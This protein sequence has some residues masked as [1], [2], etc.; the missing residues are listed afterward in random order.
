[1]KALNVILID[2]LR[3]LLWGT[4]GIG[5]TRLYSQ[6]AF[7]DEFLPMEIHDFD[8][9]LPILKTS[10]RDLPTE[11]WDRIN[12]E[13]YQ[14]DIEHPGETHQRFLENLRETNRRIITQ[15]K[16][17]P[18]TVVLD[19]MSFANNHIVEEIAFNDKKE[20]PQ[21]EHYGPQK[22]H[23]VK[24]LQHLVALKCNVVVVG[25]EDVERRPKKS[26]KEGVG[27]GAIEEIHIDVTGK[28]VNNIPRYFNECYY[29]YPGFDEM[30]KAVTFIQTQV[31]GPV[32]GCKTS[33]PLDLKL[34]EPFE[35]FWTRV[36]AAWKKSVG[37]FVVESG[38]GD[39]VKSAD[40]AAG[41]KIS[42]TWNW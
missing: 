11:K 1:M 17:A 15:S 40:V 25:H 33:F 4:T 22:S 12:V 31:N 36:L 23:I 3:I 37:E 13:Q 9:G 29:L 21:F 19:S 34:N 42:R 24:Y 6:M 26:L 20:I 39:L 7:H 2:Y 28:L 10:L 16:E 41:I 8:L 27:A 32:R 5:K 30:G 14:F 35:G 18:R 38:N